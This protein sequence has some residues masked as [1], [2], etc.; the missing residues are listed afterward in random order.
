MLKH[1]MVS[2]I[3]LGAAFILALTLVPPAGAWIV[4]MVISAV[5]QWEFYAMIRQ[6]QI[7]CFWVIGILC[8]L[9]LITA[10]F[11]SAGNGAFGTAFYLEHAILLTSVLAIFIRQFPQK[12]NPRPIETIACTLLG[13]LYV[14]YLF[15][16]FT[17][18]AF[19]WEN[20]ALAGR[21]SVTGRL[22]I[23]YL[24]LVVKFTDIGAYFTGRYLGK[25]KLFPRISPAKTWE[26]LCGGIAS[27]LT[28][29]VLFFLATDGRMGVVTLRAAD[30]VLLGIILPLTAVVGDLFE[31]LLKRACSIKDSGSSVPGMGGLLDVLDSLFFGAPML[32]IYIRLV[33]WP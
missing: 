11:F 9:A 24:V 6:A 2:G 12:N 5:A 30:A 19:A 16:F 25:H 18:L 28:V 27:A 10:T 26:G 17:R 8:G 31:S 1:R 20:H 22:L 29:S 23:L 3:I 15:N 7:P 14:P 33:L 32:Y 21:V 4:L 13:I